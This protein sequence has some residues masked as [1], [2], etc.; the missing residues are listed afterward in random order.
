[1]QD[2]ADEER[3]A[4]LLPVVPPFQRALGIDQDVSDVLNIAD[5]PFALANFQERIVGAAPLM[6]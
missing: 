6:S 1:M 2:R 3:V 5:F 4:R